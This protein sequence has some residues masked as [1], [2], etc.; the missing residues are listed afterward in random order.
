MIWIHRDVDGRLLTF[1]DVVTDIQRAADAVYRSSMYFWLVSIIVL[2]AIY[3]A[4][5]R[6][7]SKGQDDLIQREINTRCVCIA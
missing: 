2:V 7:G 5:Y 1:H 3:K 6:L 4:W